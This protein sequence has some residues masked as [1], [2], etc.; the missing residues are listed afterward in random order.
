MRKRYGG[1]Y[2]EG[3]WKEHEES[4]RGNTEIFISLTSEERADLLLGL[5]E[6]SRVYQSCTAHESGIL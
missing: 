5:L 3:M 4:L 2:E 6:S 1:Q